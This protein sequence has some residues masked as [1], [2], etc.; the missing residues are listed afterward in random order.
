MPKHPKNPLGLSFNDQKM[1]KTQ[2]NDIIV[3]IIGF[4]A[5]RST[6]LAQSRLEPVNLKKVKKSAQ[7]FFSKF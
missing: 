6:K 7:F 5:K 2:P 1:T 3:Y 4:S